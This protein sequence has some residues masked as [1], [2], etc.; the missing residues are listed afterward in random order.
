MC[1]YTNEVYKYILRK[2]STFLIVNKQNITI[3]LIFSVNKQ[4]L[5]ST[6]SYKSKT[7]AS[8]SRNTMRNILLSKG[9]LMQC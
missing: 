3:E 5:T 8:L 2:S 1:T 7:G 4:L 9:D 6:K